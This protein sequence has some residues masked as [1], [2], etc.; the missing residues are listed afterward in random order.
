MP[1]STETREYCAEQVRGVDREKRTIEIV[2]S[3]YSLD[4]YG[5]RFDQTGWD[6][7]R[8]KKNPVILT[9]HNDRKFV[10]AKALTETI[11]VVAQESRMQIKFPDEGKH[12]EADIAFNLY[13]DGF[14]RGVS[15]GFNPTKWDDVDESDQDGNVV[16]VRIFRRM[17]LDEVSLCAIPSNENALA[18]RCAQM[19]I[20]PETIRTRTRQL[21]EA[22]SN[23]PAFVPAVVEEHAIDPAEHEK[24][25]SYFERK[26]PANKAATKVLSKYFKRRDAEQPADEV[27]AW[28]R[29]GE[30][31]DEQPEVKIEE[32]PVEPVAAEA[33]EV[34]PEEPTPP[35]AAPTSVP[36]PPVPAAPEPER[37][38]LVQ[39]PLT[40]LAELPGKMARSYVET[41]VAALQRGTPQRDV[42]KLIDGANA[43][44]TQSISTL[45]THGQH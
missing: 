23:A 44:V 36:T 19:N 7:E 32:T 30:L 21:E 13:A 41:A 3:D 34:K 5:T 25:R 27:E 15:V 45:T 10:V 20:D 1:P 14:M 8:F 35:E 28:E 39:I 37:A 33:A 11:R 31:L 22:L 2:F 16:R 42:A 6:F 17:R 29:M 26:Q 40:L 24:Y 4:T 9:W 38:A 12:P 43:A 18:V